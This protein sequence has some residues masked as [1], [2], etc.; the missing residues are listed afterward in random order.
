MG[1]ALNKDHFTP[2]EHTEYRKRL[3]QQLDEL[4]T[5]I[6][7][8]GFS[9][10]PASIGAELELYITDKNGLPAPYNEELL[11]SMAHPLLTEELNRFNLEINLS[12]VTAQGKPFSAMEAELLPILKTLRQQAASM[13][14]KIA[15]IGILPTLNSTHLQRDYMTDRARYRALTNELSALKGEPFVVDING[16]DSL[17][18]SC[19]EVTLEGANTSFQ[20]HLKVSAADFA[21]YFNAAQLATSLVLAISGNSPTFLGQRLWQE[22]RI[23]LFK[24]SIDS[25]HPGLT[26]WRQPSRVSFGHG[27]VRQGAWEL[28][29]ENVALHCPLMP[30]ISE[31]NTPFAELCLHHG[32][33][34][35]WNRPVFEHKKGGHLR[36]EYRYLPAG[37]SVIDMMA[38]AALAIGLTVALAEHMP[39]LLPKVP[40]PYAEFNF[41]RA[42][43]HGL[44]ASI[45]WPLDNQHGLRESRV[46][47][48]IGQL[49][50]EAAKGLEHLEVSRSEID[51]LLSVVEKR[52]S[53]GVTGASWQLNR[54][55]SYLGKGD[56]Q[57]ALS[58][59]L[60][61]YMHFSTSGEP[62]ANWELAK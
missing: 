49:L 17:K 52:L 46:T 18:M 57:Q 36:I 24:Q 27:W 47:E 43:Q 8:P 37:P 59:M 28:F 26:R 51:S 10:G 40:F 16:Q 42:A 20:V 21:R 9:D 35:S 19:D 33:V 6:E 31:D 62:V 55:D 30:Y 39:Q 50:P 23:A 44:D 11:T 22:T 12:P 56:Q 1:Q 48:I 14:A 54:L 58:R 45:L 41:Y 38:N 4:K 34:W 32:T 5:V 7:Q 15:T 29:A 60:E 25:R 53:H 2:A 13:D 61:D 3:Q